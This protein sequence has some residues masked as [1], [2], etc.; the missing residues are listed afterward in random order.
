[1]ATQTAAQ[2]TVAAKAVAEKAKAAKFVELAQKRATKA[3]NSIR[4]IGKLASGNYIYTDAQSA[5]ICEALKVEVQEL[6]TRFNR[7]AKAAPEGFK[8]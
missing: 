6:H 3:I 8:L 7:T 2:K 5:K 4:S 1:M